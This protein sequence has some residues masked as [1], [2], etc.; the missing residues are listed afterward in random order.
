MRASRRTQPYRK[1]G[2]APAGP[3]QDAMRRGRTLAGGNPSDLR[4]ALQ[5]RAGMVVKADPMGNARKISSGSPGTGGALREA[6]FKRM[7]KRPMKPM[8]RRM[9]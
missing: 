3:A 4:R 1:N 2:G 8:R 5:K 9:K 6:L 7:A